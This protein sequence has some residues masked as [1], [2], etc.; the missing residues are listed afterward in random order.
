MELLSMKR[1][2]QI[3]IILFLVTTTVFARLKPGA[4]IPLAYQDALEKSSEASAPQWN[5]S[6]VGTGFFGTYTISNT[7]QSGYFEPPPGWEYFDDTF[8]SGMGVGNGRTGEFPKGTNQYY[9]WGAGL[10]VGARSENFNSVDDR[11]LE[12]NRNFEKMGVM[13]SLFDAE[14]NFVRMRRVVKNVRVANTAYYSDQSAISLLWQSDQRINGATDGKEPSYKGEYR[15]GQKNKNLE[16]F[17]DPW[18]YF[19]PEENEYYEAEMDTVYRLDHIDINSRRHEL[20]QKNPFL[21]PE[22]VL[23]D[24]FREDRM[25][26]VRGDVVSDEDT[27]AVFGD[28]IP[29]RNGSFIWLIGYDVQPLG[30]RVTQRTYSWRIDDYL[31]INYKIKNMNDFPLHD[32][33]VGYFMDNDVGDAT[34]DMIGFDRDLNLGYSYDSDTEEQGWSTSAG[35]V[36]SVFVETPRKYFTADSV[37]TG[38]DGVDNDVDGLTDESD[39][40]DQIG[41]TGFQTWIRSDLG[42]SEGF[43][44]DVD[45]NETD[46]LKYFELALQDSFEVYEEAQDVRQLAASGPFLQLEPGEEINITIAIVAGESLADLKENTKSAVKKYQNG[47]IGPESPPA[48]EL[49]VQPAHNTVYLAW[50]DSPEE[51][52]D[53]FTGEQDFA[54]YRVYRSETG[55]QDDWEMLAEYDLN[56]DSTQYEAAIKY[57]IGN[58]NINAELDRVLTEGEIKRSWDYDH[59]DDIFKE[60]TYTIEFRNLTINIDGRAVDTLCVLVYDQTKGQSLD[61]NL[62]ALT[63]GSGYT[64][65]D[66]RFAKSYGPIY[67][68]GI[69]VYF[70]G[71]YIKMTDGEYVDL[72]DNGTITQDEKDQQKLTPGIGDVFEITTYLADDIGEQSGIE[73][74]YEDDDL[75]DGMTY[76]Y[77]VTSFDRGNRAMNIPEMESS[78]YENIIDVKPQHIGLEYVGEPNLTS[79][80]YIGTGNTT[81]RI[82]RGITEHKNLTGDMYEFQFFSDNPFGGDPDV[83]NYG[84]VIDRDI[85]P[86]NIINQQV[87]AN[88]DSTVWVGQLNNS[89][90]IPGSVEIQLSGQYT[91]TLTDVDSLSGALIGDEIVHGIVN[92]GTGMIKLYHKDKELL[93]ASLTAT[94]SYDYQNIVLKDQVTKEKSGSMSF[95]QNTISYDYIY[96]VMEA[97]N[98]GDTTSHGFIIA[99]VSP[100][101]A[102]DSTAWS[103]G[104]D[105]DRV[106]LHE[107]TGNSLEPYDFYVTFPEGGSHSAFEEFKHKYGD[108]TFTQTVPWKIW[109]RTLDIE[110]RSWNPNFPAGTDNVVDWQLNNSKNMISVLHESQRPDSGI[111]KVSFNVKFN[112]VFEDDDLGISD[113]LMP[114]TSEDTLYIFTS[115]PLKINDKFEMQST[116][117]FSRKEDINLK[118]IRVVPNPYYIRAE[119]DT[120]QYTQHIDFRHLPSKDECVTH[121]RIFNVA[122]DLVAHLKKNGIVENNETADE[123]GTVSW[124]LRN[125]ESLKV[126]SGL[127]IYHIEAKIDGKKVEHVGKF[128]IIL[129]P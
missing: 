115:R 24:P 46:H 67:K 110:S 80:T 34:D 93:E 2:Y 69:N 7:G 12:I 64:V 25:G 63:E 39:E 27:Y 89:T 87:Q 20:L 21:S 33:F 111:G 106:F 118:D 65:Y 17:Q 51:T 35:Y 125:F 129:G 113:T 47:Y 36:G 11:M 1:I 88:V 120:D 99:P 44:G 103:W 42:K 116:K 76:Y 31:Y 26:N 6:W 61:Y 45:D 9:V 41:L 60:S 52:I 4:P 43:G 16:E 91:G 23:L 114:P 49:T 122:G 13:D 19:L 85:Q 32:V 68:S 94:V 108:L 109:N 57:K 14:G 53:P 126:T 59:V 100:K 8:P 74:S 84:I 50:D 82:L 29:E 58:S 55:L 96:E 72:D 48:P 75:T 78:Y 81:G 95:N 71:I 18:S 107:A 73:Y 112:A 38:N 56:D 92:Y 30:V 104:T 3:F 40:W 83:A 22:Q 117:M 123:H 66:G 105:V 86:I 28:Y 124:N 79:A 119:W 15:F 128:A 54:G 37:H 101:L 90:I 10:W 70:N 62:D 127:Y 97:G 121:V 98:G 102:V 5:L 77:A